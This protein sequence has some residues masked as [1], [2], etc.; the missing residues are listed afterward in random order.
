MYIKKNN[1]IRNLDFIICDMISINIAMFIAYYIRHGEK[2]Y[3][4]KDYMLLILTAF[5][6][7]ICISFF[8]DNY[9]EILKRGYFQEFRKVIV[10]NVELMVLLVIYMFL[11]Q[12]GA[13][14]SRIVIVIFGILDVLIMYIIRII[15]KTIRKKVGYGSRKKQ[16]MLVMTDI[17][18][19]YAILDN[20]ERDEEKYYE[21][22]GIALKDN[23][24]N[25]SQINGI[26]VVATGTESFLWICKNVVDE[27]MLCIDESTEKISNI[28][29]KLMSIGVVVNLKLDINLNGG[30]Q[31]IEKINDIN[32]VKTS[33]NTVSLIDMALKRIIDIC[34]G[35][36]G[37]IITAILFI[38]VALAIKIAD[39]KGPIFFQQTRVG[40][41]GRRFTI[42]KFRSMYVDAEERKKELMKNN[43]MEGFMFKMDAD[44]RIIGS[45]LDGT[46][47]GLGYYLRRLSID[48]FPNFWSILKG[49]MSLVGTRPPTEDEYIQYE[50]HHK[51]RLAIKPGLT[52]L[53][54]VSGRS[55]F[56]NFEEIVKLDNEYIKNWNIGLDIKI[57]L[58]T[59]LVVLGRKGVA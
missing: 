29:E 5:M 50:L 39:P 26:E 42:Y 32:V 52:G 21:V 27:V 22:I 2:L 9:S 31:H 34:A 51:S 4:K 35:V 24:E 10:H 11:T 43:K 1:W 13:I 6:L 37:C 20:I 41:N 36:V 18:N 16:K 57:I 49:D 33:V 28:V 17:K 59:V 25:I 55:D 54:Q 8:S 12:S 58:K 56:T 30:M 15:V 14:Y 53:W 23:P 48:E 19:V 44:P 47:K 38:F 46:K 45:G 40:K 7:H 3:I